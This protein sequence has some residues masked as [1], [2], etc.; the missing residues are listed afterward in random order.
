MGSL[1]ST[2]D[3]SRISGMGIWMDKVVGNAVKKKE[4]IQK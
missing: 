3:G 2:R 4:V 1:V